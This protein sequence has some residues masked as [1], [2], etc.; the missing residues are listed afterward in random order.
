MA[1]AFPAITILVAALVLWSA[2]GKIRGDPR[3]VRVVH[4]IVGVP[5]KYFPT[6][7]DCDAAA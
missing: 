4:E 1:A 5:L 3:I 2:V 7:A 6:L